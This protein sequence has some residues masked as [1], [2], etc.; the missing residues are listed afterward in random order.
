MREFTCA[1]KAVIGFDDVVRVLLENV[2]GTRHNFV[3]D[4]RVDRRPVG[5]HLDPTP[6]KAH[7]AGEECP[8]GR[9]IA[10]LREQHVDHLPVLIDCPVEVSPARRRP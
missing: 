9:G 10:T 2:P 3:E 7:R 4:A 1:S 5:G 6:T 8:C